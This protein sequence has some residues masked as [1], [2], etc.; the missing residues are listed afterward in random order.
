MILLVEDD[1]N[2]VSLILRVLKQ[3]SPSTTIRVARNGEE[4]LAVLESRDAEPPQLILLDLHLPTI[5]GLQVLQE[6]RENAFTCH[7][8]VVML[9]S[10]QDANDVARSYDLGANSFLDKTDKPDQFEDTVKLVIAYWLQLNH[11]YVHPGV[12]RR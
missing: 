6:L 3:Q 10:S 4:A 12:S 1:D 2:D 5:S 11:P 8:P 9:S 7:T